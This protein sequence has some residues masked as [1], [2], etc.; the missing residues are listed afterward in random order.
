LATLPCVG[1]VRQ[2][3]LMAGIELVQDRATKQ[4][5]PPALRVGARVCRAARDRGVLLRPL[6]DVI[7][8]L[9]PL[10]IELPLLDRLCDV[11]YECVLAVNCREA[12]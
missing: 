3:G 2:K 7:V 9:P 8:I 12:G 6:G 11:V 5:F 1:D 4:P 10:A